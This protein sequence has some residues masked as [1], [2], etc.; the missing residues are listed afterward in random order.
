MKNLKSDFM[1][2]METLF[3]VRKFDVKFY[4]NIKSEM[5]LEVRVKSKINIT[6]SV[7]GREEMKTL[8]TYTKGSSVLESL[9]INRTHIG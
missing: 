5:D 2:L 6:T 1:M 8:H 7:Y 9:K 4:K 3:K